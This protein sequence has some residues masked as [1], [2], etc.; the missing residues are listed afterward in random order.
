MRALII[1]ISGLVPVLV[2]GACLYAADVVDLILGRED[3]CSKSSSS[4][5]CSR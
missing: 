2:T 1:I 5:R 4:T 3:S